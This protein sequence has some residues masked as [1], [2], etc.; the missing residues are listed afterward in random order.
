MLVQLG[1]RALPTDVTDLFLECHGRIRRFLGFAHALAC[2]SGEDEDGTRGIAEQI[3]RYFT[4]AFPLH[5]ADENDSVFPRLAAHTDA[6]DMALT[7]LR[8]DHADHAAIDHLVALCRLIARDPR[9]LAALAYAL[10]ETAEQLALE[11]EAHLNLEELV[12]FPALRDLPTTE[13]EEIHAEMRQ[14]RDAAVGLR[15]N[16]QPVRV[17]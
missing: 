11:L 6:L 15:Q 2:S 1:Q 13:R 3:V 16:A 5:V 9:Q 12:I 17:K 8:D 14:R 4:I 10:R 7:L